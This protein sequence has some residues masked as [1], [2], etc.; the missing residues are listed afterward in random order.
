MTVCEC[1]VKKAQFNEKVGTDLILIKEWLD[2][3]ATHSHKL[4][5][6]LN[7]QKKICI[8]VLVDRSQDQ[9]NEILNGKYRKFLGSCHSKG[10]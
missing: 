6:S 3:I 9:I 10:E 4:G 8:Q 1:C 5:T 7:A 2:D